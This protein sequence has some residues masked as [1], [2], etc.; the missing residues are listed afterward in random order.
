MLALL[1]FLP[2]LVLLSAEVR[3]YSLF[4]LLIAAALLALEKAFSE[5]SGFQLGVFAALTGLALLTHY[6]AVWSWLAALAYGTVRLARVG[7]LRRFARVWAVSHALLGAMLV[8]LYVSHISKL[9]GSIPEREAQADWLRAD[10]FQAGSLSPLHFLWRQT[11]SLFEFLF[12][13]GAAGILALCLVLL[14]ITGLALRRRPAAILLALPFFFSAAAGLLALY[15]Y[16]GT[17][18]SMDLIPFGCAAIASALGRFTDERSWIPLVLGA[19]MV[20]A[21]FAVSGW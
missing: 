19:V 8:W 7:L 4:L 3:G 18:H 2:S 12:S 14:G 13:P 15:P 20:P 16:G 21:A 11:L 10:Y 1:A 9:R 6:S 17:R 5:E